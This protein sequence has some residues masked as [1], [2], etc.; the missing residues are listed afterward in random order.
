MAN[1]TKYTEI[2]FDLICQELAEG[3]SIR[4]VLNTKE[5]PERPTWECFRQ[6]INK[7]PERRDKYT[8]AKQDGCEYLLANAEEYINKSINKSQNAID[9]NSKPDLAQTHL[10][11]AYLDL[12]KWKSERIASKIY[13]KKDNLSLS[14]SNKDPIIIKWQD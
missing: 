1:K 2:L 10:I 6:W 5:R 3:Q 14:G 13:A 4:E 8:Q 9:K 12:A 11:K 7:Y